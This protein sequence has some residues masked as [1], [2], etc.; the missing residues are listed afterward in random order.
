MLE[1]ESSEKA[2]LVRFPNGTITTVH[3]C[4]V[5][6]PRVDHLASIQMPLPIEICRSVEHLFQR[7]LFLAQIV[8]YHSIAENFSLKISASHVQSISAFLVT[9]A[10]F[11]NQ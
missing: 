9:L 5:I 1:I 7:R 2:Y 11:R 6:A 10:I 4:D 8:Q 3:C